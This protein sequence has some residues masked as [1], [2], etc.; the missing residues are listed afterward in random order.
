MNDAGRIGFLIS[1]EYNNTET[2]DFLDVVYYG[3][4]SYVAKKLTVGNPPADNNEYW[5]ALAKVPG[6][7]VLGVK[8][9]AETT[10]RTANVNLTAANIGL[11]N[12]NNTADSTKNVATANQVNGTYTGSGG[13]QSPSYVTSGKTRFNM[14]NA[15]KG[16]TNPAGGYMDVILMDN[17]TGG[18]VPYV[19]GIGVTKNNGNPRM[20]IANGPKGGTGN[21]SHQVE[22]ITSSNISSQN[23]ASSTKATQDGNGNN[24]VNTYAKKSIYGDTEVSL[25]RKSGTISGS[26]SFVLG[27]DNTAESDGSSALG[28]RDN[29]SSG[30]YSAI[31]GGCANKA[32]SYCSA[33]LD[34]KSTR[35]NSSHMA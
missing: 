19:T 26:Y 17:Y 1:G 10:Y 34:R 18:D 32:S 2:Y 6:S 8:G 13:Q 31:L 9:N 16:I 11:G 23:V 7:T 30:S 14:W 27:Y 28:G 5:Q 20:F 4:S 21:W 35:L 22:V 3:N 33:T 24:I 29:V 12:V 15:F 25:G